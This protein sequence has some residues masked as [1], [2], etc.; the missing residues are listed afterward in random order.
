[1]GLRADRKPKIE[2]LRRDEDVEGLAEAASFSDP[3]PTPDGSVRDM[4]APVRAE[5]ILALGALGPEAGRHAVELG[6]TDESDRVRCA[7][8]RVLHGRRKIRVLVRA[9]MWLPA[10]EG[11]SRRLALRAVYD[12]RDSASSRAIGQAL[13]H[14]SDEELLGEDEAPLISALLEEKGRQEQDELVELLIGLLRSDRAIVADRSADLL[15]R[16]ASAGTE[17]V[18]AEVRSGSAAAEAAWVLG[19]IG[20]PQ[21]VDALMEAVA[22]DDPRVRAES[23]AALGALRDPVAVK[24]LLRATRDANHRVRTEAGMALDQLG[25]AAVIVGVAALLRPTIQEAVENAGIHPGG[26]TNGRTHR[27]TAPAARPPRK[28][29][30]RQRL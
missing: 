25:N 30:S 24:P 11:Q 23:A 2:S 13:V 19:Q 20:D 3:R 21:T 14:R 18:V 17:R 6:L 22:H 5:A 15:V 16:L 29:A 7:A 9:L 1:M 4:G 28:P 10:E 8:I 26:E 27:S 12:L